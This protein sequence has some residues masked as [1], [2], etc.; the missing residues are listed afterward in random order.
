MEPNKGEDKEKRI[1]W[2]RLWGLMI[3]P[4]FEKLGCETQIEVDLST[5]KQLLDVVVIKKKGELSWDAVDQSLYEGFENLNT[6]NLLSFKSF[7]EVFNRQA[8]EELYGHLAN[9]RK[10]KKIK[11]SADSQINLYVIS[12]HLP[13]KLFSPF[14]GTEFL[15][16]I[17]ADYIYDLKVFKPIRFIITRHIEH[18]ILG[19]FSNKKDQIEKSQ[20]QLKHYPWLIKDVSGYLGELFKHYSLEGVDMPYTKEMFEKEYL[21]EYYE[22][23][24][25]AK[26]Q[27]KHEKEIEIA[28]NMLRESSEPNFIAKVTGLSLEEIQRL[29]QS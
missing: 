27:A 22:K 8:L 1:S 20:E 10:I 25:N 26:R 23:M 7:N 28:R 13:Q 2:H 3:S 21:T 18:P 17:K 12:H 29:A 4:L 9:F 11:D 6:W 14:G 24:E 15:K 5:K 19:L 16:C